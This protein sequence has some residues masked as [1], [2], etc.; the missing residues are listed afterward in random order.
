VP[1]RPDAAGLDAALA[2]L[3]AGDLPAVLQATPPTPRGQALRAAACIARGDLPGGILAFQEVARARDIDTALF[4]LHD[5][6]RHLLTGGQVRSAERVMRAILQ[7][8]PDHGPACYGLALVLAERRPTEAATLLQRAAA[9]PAAPLLVEENRRR[10]L[11]GRPL[12]A[13]PSPIPAGPRLVIMDPGCVDDVRRNFAVDRSVQRICAARGLPCQ[14]FYGAQAF[15]PVHALSGGP[16]FTARVTFRPGDLPDASLQH[17]GENQTLRLDLDALPLDWSAEDTVLLH[18]VT[19][20]HLFGLLSWYRALSAP[21]P[22]LRVIL[23]YPPEAMVHPEHHQTARLLYR[24]VLSSWMDLRATPADV[25]FMADNAALTALYRELGAEVECCPTP[26][27]FPTLADVFPR[28]SGPP[29]IGF[30]ADA[31]PEKGFGLLAP[32]VASV[33]AIRPDVRF[34]AQT[35]LGEA[36]HIAAISRAGVERIDR[37]L[38]GAPRLRLFERCDLIWSAYDPDAYR[39]RTSHTFT[40]ALCLGRP[41]LASDGTTMAAALR[42][43]AARGAGVIANYDPAAIATA[44]LSGLER[45]DALHA[46]AAAASVKW[47]NAHSVAGFVDRILR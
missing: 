3:A 2:A 34:L 22:R 33:R 14:T 39:R 16:H 31:A 45:L 37:S 29:T 12:I 1:P 44:I 11:G 13:R 47:R 23:R 5:A 24:Q 41:V 30:L 40:E 9:A 7:I 38:H 35:V 15:G 6:A 18:T 17:L 28:Q 43:E 21:R 46:G 42:S 20:L 32:V 10:V 19:H 4:H 27:E 25:R 26:V 36:E 8:V